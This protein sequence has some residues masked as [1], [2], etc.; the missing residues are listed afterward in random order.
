MKKKLFILIALVFCLLFPS[1]AKAETGA[2]YDETGYIDSASISVLENNLKEVARKYGIDVVVYFT[3]EKPASTVTKQGAE[4]FDKLGYDDGII[5][6][7]NLNPDVSEFDIITFGSAQCIRGYIEEGLDR[8][9][10]NLSGGNLEGSIRSFASWIDSAYRDY[11][12]KGSSSSSSSKLSTA[13]GLAGGTGLL[14][15]GI[16]TLIMKGQLK[17]EGKKRTANSYVT[18]H[19]FDVTRGG[20]LFMYR[21][22]SRHK[23]QK[24]DR[25]NGSYETGKTSSGKS[26]SAGGGRHF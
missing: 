23:I 16:A 17:S 6:I 25:G 21:E 2:V 26:Y 5:M 13:L 9:V 20:E 7:V 12:D 22:V 15:A 18:P 8:I 24:N 4:F 1:T 11:A 19:S 10:D 14:G 3:K